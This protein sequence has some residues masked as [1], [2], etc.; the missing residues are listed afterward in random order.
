MDELLEK[1]LSQLALA[2]GRLERKTDFILKHL[3]LEFQ[4]DPESSI[5]AQ[6]A[7]VYALL[8]KGK[9]IDAIRE[10][11]KQT[12]ADVAEATTAVDKIALGVTQ[13]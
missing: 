8:K 5:P 9:K 4:D 3:N 11:R 12:G 10:Y 13:K 6:L 2:I 7:E 1:R